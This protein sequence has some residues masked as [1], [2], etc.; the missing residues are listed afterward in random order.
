MQLKINAIACQ[1]Q[2][3]DLQ[4]DLSIQREMTKHG[5]SVIALSLLPNFHH[6][7]MMCM[8]PT[9]SIFV[10]LLVCVERELFRV[11]NKKFVTSFTRF[12]L[13]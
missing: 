9:Y 3:P 6:M 1:Q 7:F 13:N 12:C 5:K 11:L 10:S 4:Q 8:Y 2:P